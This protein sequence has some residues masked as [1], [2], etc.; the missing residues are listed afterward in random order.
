METTLAPTSRAKALASLALKLSAACWGSATVMTKAVL[1]VLP[2]FLTLVLQLSASVAVLWAVTLAAGLAPR[3]G[4]T[5]RRAALGG[6]LEPGLAYGVGIPGL[7]LTSAANAAVI[8]AAEPAA[9]LVLG[10]V[11]WR[12][13][14]GS[15]LGVAVTATML[16]VWLITA[17]GEQSGG[18]SLA[19]DALVVLGVIFAALY[20]LSSS[21]FVARVHPLPLAALQQSLGLVMALGLLVVAW[22][23]GLEAPP[24]QLSAGMVMAAMASGIVQYALAF[25]LYLVGLRAMPVGEAGLFLALTP[26]FGVVAAIA[27]LGESFTPTQAAGAAMVVGAV[28]WMARRQA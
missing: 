13:P 16:G 5:E 18:A 12:S 25:W 22:P 27:F 24:R 17:R 10:W 15:A 9:I 11:L 6:L 23:T 2:P 21:R 19:G 8:G 7:M 4:A 28:A 3:L 1:E 20:L 14:I 26:V